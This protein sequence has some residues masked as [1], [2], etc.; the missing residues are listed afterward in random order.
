[1]NAIVVRPTGGNSPATDVEFQFV[2]SGGP[3]AKVLYVKT[4]NGAMIPLDIPVKGEYNSIVKTTSGAK[5]LLGAGDVQSSGSLCLSWHYNV[6][7][8][9]PSYLHRLKYSVKP[10]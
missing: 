4:L 7:V 8:V 9:A 2:E 10:T 1:M 6:I 3:R 5:P